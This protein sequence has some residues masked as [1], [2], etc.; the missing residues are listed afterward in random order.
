MEIVTLFFGSIVG[1][2]LGRSKYKF[3][4]IHSKRFLVIE[5]TYV[6]LKI[7]NRSFISLTNPYQGVGE[8]TI[9]QKTKDFVDFANDFFNYVDE[10]RIF[11]IMR[12]RKLLIL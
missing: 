2:I 8:K 7:A 5:E 9:D 10:K 11:L 12:K 6:R 3:E 1:F 4:Q